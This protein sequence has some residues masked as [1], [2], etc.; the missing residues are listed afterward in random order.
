MDARSEDRTVTKQN[1]KNETTL[2]RA[3]DVELVITRTFNAPPK[4]VFDAWTKPEL[5]KR[6]WAPKSRTE[7]LVSIEADVRKGG[8]YRYV[9]RPC[10]PHPTFA[11]RGTYLELDPHTR[12]VCTEEFEPA[13]DGTSAGEGSVNTTTFEARGDRTHVVI[14]CV[15]P[16]KEVLDIV[17]ATGMEGGMRESYEQLEELVTSLASV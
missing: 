5:V 17:I 2:E 7:E 13:A 3:S 12:I 16:S 6:W 10:A 11:F 14:R 1:N 4:L 9:M 8:N 15:Y